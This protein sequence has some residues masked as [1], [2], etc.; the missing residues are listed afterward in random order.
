MDQTSM[1]VCFGQHFARSDKFEDIFKQGMALVE[2]TAAYLDGEGRKEAKSLKPPVSVVYATQSM[3]LTTRLLDLASWLLIQRSLKD[4]EISLKDA[5]AKREGLKLRP[6]GRIS[7][8]KHFED[9]PE[10][11]KGLIHQSYNL[12]DRLHQID[13]ALRG[14]IHDTQCRF[15]PVNEQHRL[16]EAR[17]KQH[18]PS[19]NT[20]VN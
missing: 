1:M 6:F 5:L 11:L 17:F 16:L 18:A 13:V 12:C 3:R 19:L 15:D 4:G 10:G 9:L 20:F 14:E 8:I 2:R 7:H